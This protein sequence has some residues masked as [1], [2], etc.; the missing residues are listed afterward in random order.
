MSRPRVRG[1]RRLAGNTLHLGAAGSHEV[2]RYMTRSHSVKTLAT[3]REGRTW[4][5]PARSEIHS[6]QTGVR[7]AH[8][9]GADGRLHCAC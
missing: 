9:P 6:A 5:S 7:S 2:L 4:S 1:V 8:A 3:E